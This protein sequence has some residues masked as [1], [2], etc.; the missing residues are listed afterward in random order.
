MKGLR[1]TKKRASTAAK[2]MKADKGSEIIVGFRGGEERQGMSQVAQKRRKRRPV[3]VVREKVV[4]FGH[5]RDD[6]ASS[7]GRR[8]AGGTEASILQN[9]WQKKGTRVKREESNKKKDRK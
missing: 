2:I 3:I 9:S 6:G 4:G 5:W 7:S 1:S 8:G